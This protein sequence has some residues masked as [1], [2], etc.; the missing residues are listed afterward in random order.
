MRINIFAGARRLALL[1][2]ALAVIGTAV[3]LTASPRYVG[4]KVQ[5]DH[6][7]APFVLTDEDCPADAAKHY[8]STEINGNRTVGVDLCMKASDFGDRRLIPY[9]IDADR[10]VYGADKY[11]EEVHAYEL[12]LE[13]GFSL[14]PADL[15]AVEKRVFARNVQAWKSGLLFLSVALAIFWIAVW[16]VGWI[17]RG[18]AGIPLGKDHRQS[19]NPPT[20]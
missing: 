17:V 4:I 1:V 8:F 3:A 12:T 18:F 14:S 15:A 5:I 10:L 9:K 16:C 19:S 13:K 6:P 2:T 11:S 7:L 20:E